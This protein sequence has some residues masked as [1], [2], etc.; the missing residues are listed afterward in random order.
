MYACMSLYIRV[1]IGYALELL[2]RVTA[3]Q[4]S[5]LSEA[6]CHCLV[7]TFCCAVVPETSII[8]NMQSRYS[9]RTVTLIEH[10]PTTI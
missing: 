3:P 7:L 5:T 8:E 1:T 2:L 10:S 6:F 4:Q 9:N